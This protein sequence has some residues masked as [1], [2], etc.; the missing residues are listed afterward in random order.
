MTLHP[1]YVTDKNGRKTSV[2]L[3][4]DEYNKLMTELDLQDDIILYKKAK[5]KKSEF[6]PA[7]EVF[8]RIDNKRK[9]K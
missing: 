9:K 8:R 2:L 5:D 7:E 3:S 1:Q 4:I 6:I